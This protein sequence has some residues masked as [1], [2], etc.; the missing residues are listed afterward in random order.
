[1]PS[2]FGFVVDDESLVSDACIAVTRMNNRCGYNLDGLIS[3]AYL[4][5]LGRLTI[6]ETQAL[7]RQV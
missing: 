6:V 2:M 7:M 5:A 4:T 1:V 3:S